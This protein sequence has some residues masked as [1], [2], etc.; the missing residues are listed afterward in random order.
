M[1]NKK[2]LSLIIISLLAIIILTPTFA[3]AS[4][5]I[6]NPDAFD[7]RN[8]GGTSTKAVGKAKII[9]N[10]ISTAGLVIGVITL[11]IIG[12]KYMTGSVQEKAE[13][14]K[15]MFSFL[16]GAVLLVSISVIVK[17]INNITNQTIDQGTI[18]GEEE[19]LVLGD[20]RK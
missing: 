7:P 10:A 9:L 5:P 17:F 16:I 15:T 11:M 14:K 4:G 8:N 18:S 6:D 19:I 20:N 13:Y 12:I 3:M 1:K 2:I